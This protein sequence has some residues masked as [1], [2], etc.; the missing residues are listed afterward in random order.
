MDDTLKVQ[1][2]SILLEKSNKIFEKLD[3]NF[4]FKLKVIERCNSPLIS[5][6]KRKIILF[7]LLLIKLSELRKSKNKE[8]RWENVDRIKEK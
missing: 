6:L 5:V 7:T 2:E 4:L 3:L 8:K 1:R